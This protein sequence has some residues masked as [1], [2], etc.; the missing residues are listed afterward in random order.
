[1]KPK[2]T[3]YIVI[4]IIVAAVLMF[5]VC[6]L[7][8]SLQIT[9]YTISSESLPE[10]FDGYRIVQLS[11][12]HNEFFGT[13]QEKLI[14]KVKSLS[15]DLIVFTGDMIDGYHTNILAVTE[16]VEGLD[17]LCPIYAIDG[18]H[19][20]DNYAFYYLLQELYVT[21][22]VTQLD[23]ERVELWENGESITL[24][25]F[26]SRYSTKDFDYTP[27]TDDKFD[28]LL[29]H[30]ATD[31][32]RVSYLGYELVLS[33]H[34]HGG[35]IRLPFV[36]GLIGNDLSLGCEYDGGLYTQGISTMISNRGLGYTTPK[37]PRFYNRSEIVCITLRCE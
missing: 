25:G 5:F 28:M 15:P 14:E 32:N 17:G 21:H 13:D 20:H 29:F 27:A 1:M 8:S 6:G 2:R 4:L 3:K 16:L 11:D 30:Y 18:N 33:G 34:A 37:I 23:N 12:L 36:G 10:S 19:E 22:G 26:S 35:V 7:Y 9:N 24:T 31:F